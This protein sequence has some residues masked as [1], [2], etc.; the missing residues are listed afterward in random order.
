[1]GQKRPGRVEED[2]SVFQVLHIWL[3]FAE[4]STALGTLHSCAEGARFPL[5][6]L[7]PSKSMHRQLTLQGWMKDERLYPPV[8][9]KYSATEERA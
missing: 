3:P 7:L 4:D 8:K 6:C 1:V 9:D 5:Q 2:V